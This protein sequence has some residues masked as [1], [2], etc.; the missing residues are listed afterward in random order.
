MV[1]APIMSEAFLDA[2]SIALRLYEVGQQDISAVKY[3]SV[4]S[5]LFAS[6]A[7]DEGSVESIGKREF[8]QVPCGIILVLISLETT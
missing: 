7:L 6:M 5:T 4:P 1:S 8:E 2:L 3:D